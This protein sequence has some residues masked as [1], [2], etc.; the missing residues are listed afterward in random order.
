[1]NRPPDI[2]HENLFG[3]RG[4]VQVWNCTASKDPDPFVAVLLCTLDANGIVGRHKQKR[5]TESVL[6]LAGSGQVTCDSS[7]LLFSPGVSVT[8]SSEMILSI[9]NLSEVP[10]VYTITKIS[11]Q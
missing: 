9:E 1:M 7:V 8:I 6:C 4:R 3:G 10:L 2:T 5:F 11:I